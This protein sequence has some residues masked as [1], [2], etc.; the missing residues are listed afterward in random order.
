M[1][2]AASVVAAHPLL[3]LDSIVTSLL[4]LAAHPDDETGGCAGL[5]QRAAN[6]TVVYA[7]DAAPAD[8]YFWRAYGCPE[9]YAATRLAECQS[10]LRLAGVGR[11]ALLRDFSSAAARFADQQLHTGLLAAWKA[12]RNLVR[13]HRPGAVL[14]PAYEGGHPDHDGCSFLGFLLRRHCHLPVYEMPLYHRAPDGQLICRRFRECNGSEIVLRLSPAEQRV[15]AQMV[16]CYRSQSDL[17]SFV[18]GD[19]EEFRPQPPYD[20]SRPPHPGLVNYQVWQWPITP[21]EVCRG[22]AEC[23]AGVEFGPA[24][25][26]G[27]R[28]R[29]AASAAG[30]GNASTTP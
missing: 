2:S 27:A 6:P 16:A 15:R 10:A 14:V 17:G 19:W 3:R 4:V 29:P 7:T 22:F 26:A 1:H 12:L 11:P 21:L 18:F 23:L 13:I 9:R 24:E 20:Y 30:A 28:A 5:L 8:P 25:T